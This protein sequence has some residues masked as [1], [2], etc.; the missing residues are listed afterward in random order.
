[1]GATTHTPESLKSFVTTALAEADERGGVDVTG[2]SP[3][4]F[5]AVTHALSDRNLARDAALNEERAT[6]G[7][8]PET[9]TERLLRAAAN[10]DGSMTTRRT[11]ADTKK[12]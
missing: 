12:P 9:H 7:I 8:P 4:E 3:E 5:L 11:K 1:M 2:M 6:A 10:A